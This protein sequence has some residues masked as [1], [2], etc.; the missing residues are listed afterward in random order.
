MHCKRTSYRTF[1]THSYCRIRALIFPQSTSE[2]TRNACEDVHPSLVISDSTLCAVTVE[3]GCSRRKGSGVVYRF[4]DGY[5]HRDYDGGVAKTSL[6]PLPAAPAWG[7]GFLRDGLRLPCTG[8][9]IPVTLSCD[10][11]L[12]LHLSESSRYSRP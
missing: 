4:Q 1:T 9:G 12:T 10:P 2:S 3:A 11:P 8:I 6:Y 7:K 5:T